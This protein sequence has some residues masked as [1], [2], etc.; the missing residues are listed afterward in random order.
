MLPVLLAALV[1]AAV[2]L[3]R[4]PLGAHVAPPVVL[5]PGLAAV[6]VGFQLLAGLLGQP[7]SGW[8]L[9]ASLAVL[10]GFA[11][12]NRHLIGMG[13]LA[14]GL[15]LNTA[16]VVANGAM[17]VRASALVSS[18]A[19]AAEDLAAV[20]LGAGRR[21][22]RVDD[23]VPVLGDAVPVRAF[24]AAMSLGDLVVM[25]GI[26]AVTGDL[27]R[28]ARRPHPG[29]ARSARPGAR[30]LGPAL[31]GAI[32]ARQ[33]TAG[34]RPLGQSGSS[35]ATPVHDWGTAPSPAPVSGSQYSAHP[36]ATAPDRVV[37]LTDEATADD[38]TLVAASTD[39]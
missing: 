37:V 16:V 36:D 7:A 38:P 9:A 24:G 1:G 14:V 20:D 3:L 23:V 15:A 28:Y 29:R 5:V 31:A 17:P 32:T 25:A 26:G 12:A 8:S 21:F 11:A 22:E 18:G 4:H 35:A 27:V 10:L 34:G 39:R 6:G 19:V 30:R 13:V 2:G 33:V